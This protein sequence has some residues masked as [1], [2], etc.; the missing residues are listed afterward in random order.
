[1]GVQVLFDSGAPYERRMPPWEDVTA[2]LPV[3][4]AAG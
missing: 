2:A 3:L 4:T 1:M